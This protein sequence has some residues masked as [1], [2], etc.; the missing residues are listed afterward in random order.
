MRIC[1]VPSL[2]VPINITR[3]GLVAVAVDT[4]PMVLPTVEDPPSAPCHATL[5]S[6]ARSFP[7]I[8][9]AETVFASVLSNVYATILVLFTFP[10]IPNTNAA[11]IAARITVTA[12]ISIT[13][14]TG[15]TASSFLFVDTII[16]SP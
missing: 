15:D 10:A 7:P 8:H 14:M 11:M 2:N 13:P 5:E 9:V 1:V 16:D 3:V 12:T 4:D 6:D